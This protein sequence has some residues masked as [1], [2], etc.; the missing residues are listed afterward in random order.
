M[1]KKN[2]TEELW[3]KSARTLMDFIKEN[4]AIVGFKEIEGFKKC[5]DVFADAEAQAYANKR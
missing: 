1:G 2:N 3:E 4:I 5:K